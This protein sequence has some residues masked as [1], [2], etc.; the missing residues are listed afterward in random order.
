MRDG[1]LYRHGVELHGKPDRS[2]NR[3]PCFTRMPDLKIPMNSN[4]QPFAVFHETE[5]LLDRCPFFDVLQDRRVPGLKTND[6]EHGSR[7]P[8]SP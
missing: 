7:R 8:S 4:A 2:F 1:D 6:Q 3:L 5:G